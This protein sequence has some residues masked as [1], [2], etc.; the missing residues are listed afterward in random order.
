M[1]ILICEG[2]FDLCSETKQKKKKTIVKY[3]SGES[4]ECKQAQVKILI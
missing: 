2:E 1:N 4:V 3:I